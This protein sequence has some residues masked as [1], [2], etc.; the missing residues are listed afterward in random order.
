MRGIRLELLC[1]LGFLLTVFA[2]VSAL[3]IFW[4]IHP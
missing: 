3:H 1:F 4:L 2:I